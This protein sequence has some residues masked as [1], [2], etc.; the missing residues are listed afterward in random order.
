MHH[1]CTCCRRYGVDNDTAG[2]IRSVGFQQVVKDLQVC[3]VVPLHP[4]GECRV[5]EP[6]PELASLWQLLAAVGSCWQLLA[7]GSRQPAVCMLF[8]SLPLNVAIA[9]A[10]AGL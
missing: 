3:A 2:E 10:A 1:E 8:C 9:A 4:H 6:E 5:P 7:A